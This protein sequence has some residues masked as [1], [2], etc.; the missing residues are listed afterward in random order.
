MAETEEFETD[1]TRGEFFLT[2][3]P[4]GFFRKKSA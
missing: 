2:F 4:R 3:S 1:V